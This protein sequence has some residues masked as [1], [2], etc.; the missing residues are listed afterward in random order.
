MIK[1]EVGAAILVRRC[2]GYED[3]DPMEV[4]VLGHAENAMKVRVLSE[5]YFPI[6]SI[7]ILRRDKWYSIGRMKEE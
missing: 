1:Y 3:D 2:G 4:R 5:G 7:Q 6:N